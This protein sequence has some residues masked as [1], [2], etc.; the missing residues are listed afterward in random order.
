MLAY[1]SKKHMA[2]EGTRQKYPLSCKIVCGKHNVSYQRTIYR[3]KAEN[4]EVWQCEKYKLLGKNGCDLP[5]IYTNEI[6]HIL[7]LV[8]K[9]LKINK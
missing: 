4:R 5:V 1:K 7:K 2:H 3:S 6:E 8:V 9:D